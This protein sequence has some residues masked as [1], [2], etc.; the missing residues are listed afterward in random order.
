MNTFLKNLS[1]TSF[2][3]KTICFIDDSGEYRNFEV[4]FSEFFGEVYITT[5]LP[6]VYEDCLDFSLDNYGTV[7]IILKSNAHTADCSFSVDFK[8]RKFIIKEKNTVYDYLKFDERGINIPQTV[9][10][11]IPNG[12]N[13]CDF[14]GGIINYLDCPEIENACFEL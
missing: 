3:D 11:K 8:S 13:I 14:C 4:R 5:N 6:E 7:P 1:H 10:E 12:V 9:L 2:R